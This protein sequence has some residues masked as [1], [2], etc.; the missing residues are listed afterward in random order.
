[1]PKANA[2]ATLRGTVSYVFAHRFVVTTAEGSTLADL[3]PQ[4][5]E[6]FPLQVGEEVIV[7]GE[8]K[9]SELKVVTIARAGSPPVAIDA[10]PKGPPG[11]SRDA[12]AH[13]ALS[14]LRQVGLAPV[15]E[16]RRRPRHFE[17]AARRADGKLVEAHVEFDGAIRKVRALESEVRD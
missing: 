11:N 5:A 14:A 3:G 15:G 6:L 9:P 1:M 2:S 13:A 17:I 8:M 16:P 12:E 4:G 7:A 10:G